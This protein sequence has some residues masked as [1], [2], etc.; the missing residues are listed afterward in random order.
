MIV[1][2]LNAASRG[3]RGLKWLMDGW[4]HSDN[5]VRIFAEECSL[6][7]DL[8]CSAKVVW[9]GLDLGKW[10]LFFM[11]TLTVAW[12]RVLDTEDVTQTFSTL[13]YVDMSDEHSIDLKVF[14]AHGLK[15]R[16]PIGAAL[17]AEVKAGALRFA[18]VG[19]RGEQHVKILLPPRSGWFITHPIPPS[20]HALP[21]MHRA[22]C[23]TCLQNSHSLTKDTDRVFLC[24]HNGRLN[25]N[26]LL[27]IAY[28]YGRQI[29]LLHKEIILC[30]SSAP[31]S[32]K[33]APYFAFMPY[34][35]K[36]D[37]GWQMAH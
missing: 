17:Q 14:V 36:V 18:K 6:W 5:F 21:T 12:L 22:S 7:F 33:R 24:R 20:R 29:R 3:L 37:A 27:N 32:S 25:F 4:R 10:G 15:Q 28:L 34:C 35:S 9:F 30:Y 16:L 26:P 1:L 13:V 23:T 2:Q 11:L 8:S 19:C 31:L